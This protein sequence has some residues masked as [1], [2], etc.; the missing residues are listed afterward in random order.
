M[1]AERRHE[2]RTNTLAHALEGLPEVSRRYGSRI[3]LGVI[4]VLLVIVL[5]RLWVTSSREKARNAAVYLNN[6]RRLVAQLPDVGIQTAQAARFAAFMDPAQFATLRDNVRDEAQRNID[7]V[8]ESSD[9]PKFRAGAMVTRGDLNWELANFPALPTSITATRPALSPPKSADDYLKDA[10]EAYQA[11]VGSGGAPL[12]S[13]VMARLGLA[14]IAEN[15]Q[16]WD[17]A[18]QQYQA[19]VDHPQVPQPLKQLAADRLSGL[20]EL[21]RPVLIGQPQTQPD[22]PPSLRDLLRAPATTQATTEPTG[23]PTTGPAT[24]PTSTQPAATTTAPSGA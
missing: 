20:D 8:L 7:L 5:V 10:A 16:N 6:A 1:K 21:R 18:R 9:D 12:E 17:E 13:V 2:L 4:A 3:L 11:V 22:L 23:E 19:V 15:R 24:L 14:A